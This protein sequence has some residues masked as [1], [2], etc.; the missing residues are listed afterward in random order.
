[1]LQLDEHDFDPPGV[2]LG[3]QNLLNAGVDLFPLGQ[4]L[5]QLTLPADAPQRYLR[6]LGGRKEVILHFPNRPIRVQYS[7]IEH[8]ID[9]HRHVVAG[10]DVLR[11]NVHG[12][13]AKI[14]FHHLFNARNH[15]NHPRPPR[16]HHTAQS[17]N[18]RPFV[19]LKNFYS[20]DNENNDDN[21]KRCKRSDSKHGCLP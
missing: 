6:E 3:V 1:M 18:H 9:F 5:V 13:G 21:K 11:W 16:P 19:F 20:A 2:G 4:E 8:R 15:I 14:H 10:D 12:H 7:K 17:K